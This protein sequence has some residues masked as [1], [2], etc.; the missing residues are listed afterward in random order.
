MNN[1]SRLLA[2]LSY[3]SWVGFII[4][5]IARDK[6]DTLVRRHLNQALVINIASTLGSLLIKWGGIFGFAGGIINLASFVLFILGVI[7]AFKMSE[8]P[9]PIVGGLTLI[10]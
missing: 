5:L 10:S 4:S 7:R 8:E 3:F 6:N 2:V 9:L 1:N